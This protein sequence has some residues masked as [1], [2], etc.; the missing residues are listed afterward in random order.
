[1]FKSGAD[2]AKIATTAQHI[3][4]A[5]RV[6]ALPKKASSKTFCLACMALLLLL[7]SQKARRTIRVGSQLQACVRMHTHQ[8]SRL[9]ASDAGPVIALAMGERGMVS[10]ILAPK[11][12]GFLTFGALSA[13]KASAPGQPLLTELKGL[14]GLPQQSASTQVSKW[15]LA[16]RDLW[17]HL[18]ACEGAR[19]PHSIQVQGF[20]TSLDNRECQGAW[21][22][23]PAPGMASSRM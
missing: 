4:D 13:D 9:A 18:T 10:R 8:P 15:L 7:A 5:A 12:G 23:T 21:T 1:M 14:Y 3:Q 6:L 11:H 19:S 2:I 22:Q 17:H 20:G 16:D